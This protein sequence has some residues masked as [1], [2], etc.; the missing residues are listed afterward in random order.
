MFVQSEKFVHPP[1]ARVTAM[2]QEDEELDQEYE[3]M[4]RLN[5]RSSKDASAVK[6]PAVLRLDL[7][8][9]GIYLC[10]PP[11]HVAH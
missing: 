2:M 10:F 5:A 7:E 9:L 1:P 4:V 3:T 6:Y 8:T 11:L